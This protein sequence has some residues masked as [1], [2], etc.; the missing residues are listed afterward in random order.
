MNK[1][2]LNELKQKEMKDV[3]LKSNKFN[4]RIKQK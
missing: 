4:K 2:M 1:N 3:Q